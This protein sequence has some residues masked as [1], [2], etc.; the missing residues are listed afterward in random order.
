MRLFICCAMETL[1]HVFLYS[2][3]NDYVL[4]ASWAEYQVSKTGPFPV[5]KELQPV[6][7]TEQYPSAWSRGW[8]LL[9]DGGIGGRGGRARGD[10][11]SLRGVGRFRKTSWR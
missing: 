10:S 6:G 9:R 11:H 8:S 5:F 7:E 2:L 4:Q 1:F 3:L